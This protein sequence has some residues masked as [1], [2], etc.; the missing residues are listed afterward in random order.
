MRGERCTT[1]MKEVRNTWLEFLASR[2]LLR[3][4]V[5]IIFK[6][7]VFKKKTLGGTGLM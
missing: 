7:W 2:G 3:S 4:A 5:R 6:N 1:Q